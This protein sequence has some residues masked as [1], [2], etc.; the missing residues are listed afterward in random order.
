[1]RIL[2]ST[3][4]ILAI[5]CAPILFR[6][7][8]LREVDSKSQRELA[9][10]VQELGKFVHELTFHLANYRV[11]GEEFSVY[12]MLAHMPNVRAITVIHEREDTAMHTALLTII[13]QFSHIE[14]ITL[15]ENYYHPYFN[16][17]PRRDVEVS[18]TFFHQFLHNIVKSH[19]HRL[20]ALHLY[21]LLPL[22]EDLYIKIR[23]FTPNL[24]HITFTGN[25]PV[26]L[27]G[28]FSE[29]T[30]WAS[31]KTGSLESLTLHNCAGVHA[32]NF[33]QNVLYGVYG[34][35]L[36]S[37]FLIACGH[38]TDAPSVPAAS[39]PGRA[40]VD[41]LHLDHMWG[42]ELEA[43]SRIP[44]QDFSLTRL[45]PED[46]LRL[47]A[48]LVNGFAGMKKMRLIPR[49]VS[50]EAWEEISNA[51]GGA[52]KELQERCVHRGIQ[53]S[54]DAV[55]WPNACDVHIHL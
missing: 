44:V 25:I 47:P 14:S 52:Y 41:C 12:Q 34:S 50:V 54:F 16:Y 33:A 11:E 4:Q 38:K 30:L 22:T 43:M 6:F 23:D 24:R 53:L 31:G 35:H 55:A 28:Q 15:L 49:M 21:T 39:T 10:N 46:L 2:S 5:L 42:C 9:G 3:C 19:G 8:S 37:I 20:K 40:M 51:T 48:L 45:L 27:R 32:G 36:K 1:M 26:E 29:P 17:L 13:D 7:I 18:Q